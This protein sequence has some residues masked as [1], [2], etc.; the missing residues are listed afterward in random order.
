ML[1]RTRHLLALQ[2]CL[3]GLSG[4]Q[5]AGEVELAAEDLRFAARALGKLQVG[6]MLKTSSTSFSKNS[7]LESKCVESPCVS[8]ETLNIEFYD[9]VKL[10]IDKTWSC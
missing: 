4:Y 9:Q 10:Y 1:T 5:Q 8:R 2:D 7:V 6:S 3:L